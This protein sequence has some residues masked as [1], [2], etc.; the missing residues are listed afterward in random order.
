MKILHFLGSFL[1]GGIETLLINVVNR[2][3]SQGHEVAIMVGTDK[4]D[5]EMFQMLD[6]R[7]KLFKVD[8]PIGSKNPWF[9][10][11][12]I[13]YYKCYSPDVL[14]LHSPGVEH[15]FPFKPTKERRIVTVH[16]ETITIPFSSTVDQYIAISQCV[17]D[18]FIRQTGHDNCVI[19]YNGINVNKFAQKEIYQD[20]P[21]KLVALGRILFNVKAQDQIVEAFSKLKPEIRDNL[22]LDFWG[23][24][25]D[26]EALKQLIDKFG[27]KKQVKLVGNV[28]NTY[29]AKHL[30]NYDMIICASHH[31]GL[32]ITAIEAM[33]AG[34]PVLLSDALGFLEVTENGRYG[35]HFVHSN[36]NSLSQA[37]EHSYSNYAEMCIIAQKAVA[38]AKE[39]FSIENYVANILKLY[40][41]HVEKNN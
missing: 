31:E 30:R 27:L 7:I 5:A 24:G 18:S 22:S 34:V 40:S 21:T 35:K 14:H 1:N 17:K 16:N 29:V 12:F 6:D 4:W 28:S 11:K 8:K 41:D 26:Y 23:D 3:V 10:L 38:Y 13:Y 19:C 25:Q 9:F 20:H 36:V 15:L 2:Q 39:R 33:T 32:G 37:M